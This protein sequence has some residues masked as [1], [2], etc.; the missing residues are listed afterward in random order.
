LRQEGEQVFLQDLGWNGYFEALW[1]ERF[2][3]EDEGL[4]P[5][6]VISQ[7]RGLWRIAGEFGES[8]AEPSGKLRAIADV[9]AEVAW[10]AVGDWV[11]AE[12]VGEQRAILHWVMPRRGVFSRKAP[13]KRVEQQVIAANVD[14]AFLVAALDMDFSPRCSNGISRSVGM[15]G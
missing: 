6:R 1:K 3:S 13:G 12:T 2:G 14:M 7:Q 15:P 10:P 11:A 4:R 5:A 9:E 8:W